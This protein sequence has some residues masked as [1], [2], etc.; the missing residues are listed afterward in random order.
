MQSTTIIGADISG[1]LSLPGFDPGFDFFG[2]ATANL[3]MGSLSVG[4]EMFKDLAMGKGDPMSAAVAWMKVVPKQWHG[5]IEA[6][7]MKRQYGQMTD[8]KYRQNPL[9][10]FPIPSRGG[11]RYQPAYRKDE[12][13]LARYFT[14][15]RSLEETKQI[16]TAV[17]F[18]E[19]EHSRL[20]GRAKL[21]NAV[22]VAYLESGGRIPEWIYDLPL[23]ER[24]G[25]IK[26]AI[27]RARNK[28]KG[29]AERQRPRT[30]TSQTRQNYERFY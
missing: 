24:R 13:W 19:A 16:R 3:V 30:Y 23:Q 7:Y 18:A 17:A 29:E 22:A 1:T 11:G 27:K 21:I 5:Y 14:G 6:H 10:D 25:L 26:A 2:S 9:T 8:E 28:L 15:R 12:Q 20:K 4:N